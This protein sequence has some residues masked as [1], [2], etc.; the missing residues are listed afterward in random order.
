M[1]WGLARLNNA[2]VALATVLDDFFRMIPVDVVGTEVFPKVDV[3]EDSKA[4]YVKAEIPGLEEKDINVILKENMLTISGE[5][6]EEKTDDNAK[7]NYYHCERSFGS[8]SRTIAL[9]EGIK[10]DEV[11]ASYKNGIL[12]IE[13]P[14]QEEVKPRKITVTVN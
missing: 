1:K 11:K 9:P 8:F 14:K 13:L 2:D 10:A 12:D 5:K 6:K 4:V 3:H 7:R